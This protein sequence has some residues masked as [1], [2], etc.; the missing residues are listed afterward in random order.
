MSEKE[1]V[2][3]YAS[4]RLFDHSLT[5]FDLKYSYKLHQVNYFDEKQKKILVIF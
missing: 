4:I 5:C 2:T 1:T 3:C